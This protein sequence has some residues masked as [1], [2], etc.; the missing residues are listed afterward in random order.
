MRPRVLVCGSAVMAA[1]ILVTGCGRERIPHD[2]I[3]AVGNRSIDAEQLERSFQ[4]N[5]VWKKGMTN[6]EAHRVQLE[7]LIDSKLFAME[8][9]RRGYDADSSMR[10]YLDFLKQKEMIKELYRRE[11]TASVVVSE[12]E[13]RRAYLWMKRRVSFD[14][15]FTT[16]SARAVGYA[17]ALASRRAADIEMRLPQQDLRGT[18]TD[19]TYGAVGEELEPLVFG[20][21]LHHAAGPARVRDGYMSVRVVD[22]N[23]DLFRSEQDFAEKK[24]HIHSVIAGRKSD[25]LAMLYISRLMRDKGLALNP[26][27]FWTFAELCAKCV[28]ARTADP[29]TISTIR[30]SSDD[31][32]Y[33][34][35]DAGSLGSGVLAT[36]NDG[37]LTVHNFL[38]MLG[39]MPGSLR[40]GVRTP[41][42][43]KDAVA[44]II[45]N[46]YLAKRAK[47]M[48]L[49]QSPRVLADFSSQKDDALA[50]LW[51]QQERRSLPLTHGE[52]AEFA[53]R[54]HPPEERVF[55]R[56]STEDL[57][58]QQK[59]ERVLPERVRVLRAHYAVVVDS[60][61]LASAVARPGEILNEIPVK[62][63]LRE[64]FQ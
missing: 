41:Q 42:E 54:P 26:E 56:V 15:V 36:H 5:P 51:Y 28:P 63:Y 23:V 47:E 44:I 25:S 11:I 62:M 43:L 1:A 2:A 29:F 46:Y 34:T 16:D 27:V 61:R 24:R 53:A 38:S 22:G 50:A 52:I 39:N 17:R 6:L 8:A 19:V 31:I 49:D 45:R 12:E 7:S 9:E 14:Y 59:W 40:P 21:T 37:I 57:A 18:R 33:L 55:Y 3:V 4:F 58:R 20:T 30:V 64:V 13:Y 60:A 32:R 10:G 48:G 35:R